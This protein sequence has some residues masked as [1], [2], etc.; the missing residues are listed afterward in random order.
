[1]QRVDAGSAA[2]TVDS[3]GRTWTADRLYVPGRWGYSGGDVYSTDQAIANTPDPVL[4]QTER[5]NLNGYM[6]D[7]PNGLYRVTL[8][9]AEIY[10]GASIGSR[11]FDVQ[12]QGATAISALDVMA[13]AGGRFIAY[14]VPLL[15]T[16]SNSQLSI[17]FVNRVGFG[18]VNAIEVI[19]LAPALPTATITSSPTRTLT[20]TVTQSPTRTGTPTLTP[21]ITNTPP[22]TAT[23]TRTFTPTPTL[24][25][26][27]TNTWTPTPT[28]TYA[29]RVNAGGAAYSDS[30]G[31]PWLAD[32]AYV[33]GSWGYYSAGS[34]APPAKTYTTS[35]SIA[36]TGDPTLFQS[37]RYWET[38]NTGEVGGY[39]FT[40]PNGMYQVTLRFAEIYPFSY[41]GSRVF[42]VKL[43]G[44]TVIPAL[45]VHAQFGRY[46]AQ[47]FTFTT[48]VN[49][50]IL[51]VVLVAQSGQPA[52]NAISIISTVGPTPTPSQTSTATPTPLYTYTPTGT[53]PATATATNT[54]TPTP[55][56]T[57]TPTPT[58]TAT[59]TPT[60]TPTPTFVVRV[61]AGGPVYSDSGA[62]TW[63]A[64]KVY[65]A[66][67]W[68]Y[69]D[70]Q[71]FSYA[72][73]INNTSESKLYQSEHYWPDG[74]GYLF[75]VA[76][77]TYRVT[78]KLA[79]I[80]SSSYAGSRRFSV[81][82]E[83]VYVITGIDVFIESGGLY[84]ALDKQFLITVADGQ[85]NLDFV[86]D[87]GNP[88]INAI[89]VAWAG[90]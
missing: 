28:P 24:T 38:S 88:A 45:D 9:F 7:V 17:S 48:Q 83:D 40:V 63:Q 76:N 30:L 60:V 32:R 27:P 52:I 18:K 58:A 84:T 55:T 56:S 23:P 36:N 1:V 41:S 20:P 66:G 34:P 70:G 74:G 54:A 12:V 2:D 31:Q 13:Q 75:D 39:Q 47:D 57:Y 33:A 8:K 64:D 14:D 16:V 67:S 25:A 50:G 69:I 43:E 44:N 90:P 35:Q 65:A 81:R 61:N 89:E 6:F 79:E 21:T 59:N 51:S 26:T 29:L 10:A 22:P 5:Y 77:G 4:Y 85:L 53:P 15:V 19:A 49:D 42:D 37:E 80:Y 82:A 46:R 3:Q 78:L 87:V 86:K 71:K 11:V 72:V 62:N 73:P 68:G